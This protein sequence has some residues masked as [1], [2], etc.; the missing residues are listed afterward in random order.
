MHGEKKGSEMYLVVIHGILRTTSSVAMRITVRFGLILP[1]P[2][3]I[4]TIVDMHILQGIHAM[5]YS[6]PAI[7]LC[8]DGGFRF[9]HGWLRLM[10]VLTGP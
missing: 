8:S 3:T 5:S 1:S 10:T 7:L 4:V 6:T 2:G 9:G